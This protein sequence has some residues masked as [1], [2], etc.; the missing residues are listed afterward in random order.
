M[1]LLTAS[2]LM[3]LVS[4]SANYRTAVVSERA[5]IMSSME[6]RV[7]R[8]DD[9]LRETVVLDESNLASLQQIL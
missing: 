5:R 9:G 7:K 6:K 1:L 2:I 8:H 4:Q 3:M